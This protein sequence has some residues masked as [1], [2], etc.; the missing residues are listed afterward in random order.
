MADRKFGTGYFVCHNRDAPK[1]VSRDGRS[2]ALTTFHTFKGAAANNTIQTKDAAPEQI[3][4]G[5]GTRNAA[6]LRPDPGGR[7]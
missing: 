2:R 1:T 7:R 4:D 6:P 3:V 5:K